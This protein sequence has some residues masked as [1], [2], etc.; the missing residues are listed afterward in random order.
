M[1]IVG[2]DRTGH[3]P[4]TERRDYATIHR[5]RIP[6]HFGSGLANAPH[7]VRWQ[8]GLFWWLVEHNDSYSHIHACYFDTVLPALAMKW[9]FGKIVVYDIFDFYADM[10][11]K[12]PDRIRR[13]VKAVDLRVIG[14]VDAVILADES[15]VEQIAGARPRRLE[16]IYNSPE[17]VKGDTEAARHEGRLKVV[18]VGLLQ[19]E[20]GITT[21]LDVMSRHPEWELDLAG[22]GGDEAVIV[23]RAAALPNVRIHGKVDYR[24]TLEFTAAADVLFA[25]YDPSIPN[26]RYSSANKLFEAMLMGKPIIVAQRTGMDRTVAKHRV[27]FIVQYGAVDQ[28]EAALKEVERWDTQTQ[29]AF[30][31]HAR[32]VYDCE[33][34]WSLMR[35]RLVKLYADLSADK[36]C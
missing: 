6:A 10:L 5:L 15:R 2:W 18:Y 34:S 22:F 3:A 24:R 17:E 19:M 13:L 31:H 33:F 36:R 14:A 23:S 26:H 8:L 29:R 11:R 25:T 30:A 28:L 27:G 1:T 35:K 16:V 32:S 20:R 21:M 9:F 7:L 12:V 4:L